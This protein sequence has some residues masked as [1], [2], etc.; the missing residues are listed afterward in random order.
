MECFIDVK[1]PRC[2]D[3][4]V[5]SVFTQCVSPPLL[6]KSPSQANGHAPKPQPGPVSQVQKS[7]V[8]EMLIIFIINLFAF[9]V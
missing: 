4:Y 1:R 5:Y 6:A 3:F 7:Q 9:I 2:G 8:V